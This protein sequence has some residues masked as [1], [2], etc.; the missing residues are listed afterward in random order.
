MH[1]ATRS[2]LSC[3][4]QAARFALPAALL[5]TQASAQVPTEVTFSVDWQ[6]PLMGVQSSTGLPITEA[7]LLSPGGAI[8]NSGTPGIRIPGAF[9]SRYSTCVGHAPGVSCGVELDALSFGRDARLR[10]T[11]AYQFDLLFSVDEHAVGAQGPFAPNVAT[12]AAAN[13]AAGDVFMRRFTGA[14]P[15]QPG[16]GF[17]FAVIDGD[18]QRSTSGALYPGLG[19]KEPIPATPTVPELG[20]NLDAFDIGPPP[21]VGTR[22][23]FSLEGG[24]PDPREPNV[25]ITNSAGLQPDPNGTLSFNGADVLVIDN[26][27]VVFLYA[28]SDQLGLSGNGFDDI[29][30]LMVVEN[31]V[32]GYQP[33][34]VP[35]DW[36]QGAGGGPRDLVLFSVRR[37]SAIIGMLDSQFGI[38]ITEGDILGP[39]LGGTIGQRPSIFIAAE[40]LGLQTSRGQFFEAGDDLDALDMRDD[41]EEP[42]KDCNE[43][44]V[45]DGLEVSS[46]SSPDI[47]GNGV[48]DECESAGEAFCDCDTAAE[49]ACGNISVTG[50][51]CVNNT[52][53]GARLIGTGTSSVATDALKLTASS[54]TP[55]TFG[56]VFMGM[57]AGSAVPPFSNGRVCVGGST[58]I[59][60]A[61]TG[62][63]GS[64]DYGPGILADI[65][66]LPLPPVVTPGSTWGF[67]V[68]YRDI[69]GPCIGG[70]SNFTNAWRV[71]YTP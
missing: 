61:P 59:K 11:A 19:L 62:P 45:E 23:F 43:N 52:G 53:V 44:G 54:M 66:L 71:L 33:S 38:P 37:G 9:L 17:N 3:G 4:L 7:D 47:D 22:T 32:A 24:L 49:A 65:S 63:T 2:R 35:Y 13:E 15:F 68:W 40:S 16:A 51:G 29:D 27:G 31:G 10:P 12:E 57:T 6:G 30:A 26:A 48:P 69:G 39:P 67:Q 70:V 55:N 56:V 46:G 5:A 14:G 21:T 60:I 64:F 41:T 42:F 20:D 1:R 8:F 25:A 36:I 34:L 58:R 28:S 50:R 18:G